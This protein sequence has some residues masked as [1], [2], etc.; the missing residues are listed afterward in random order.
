MIL[1]GVQPD[2]PGNAG[3]ELLTGDAASAD[4]ETASRG[5]RVRVVNSPDA[6]TDRFEIGWQSGTPTTRVGTPMAVQVPPGQSRVVSLPRPSTTGADRIVLTGDAAPFDNT[7]FVTARPT[8]AVVLRYVGP[9]TDRS[10]RAPLYFLERALP[11][12]GTPPVTWMQQAAAAPALGGFQTFWKL[13]VVAAAPSPAVTDSIRSQAEEGA[14]ALVLVNTPEAVERLGALLGIADL[15][16]TPENPPGGALLVDIDFRHPLFAPFADPRFSDFSRMRIW[17]PMRLDPTRIPGAKVLARLDSGGPALMEVPMGRGRIV[18]V[19]WGWS[20]ADSQW[21][22]STKFV[23]FL[24]ALVDHSG[25]LPA[26]QTATVAVGDPLPLSASAGG[27]AWTLELP[28]GDRVPI[29]DS[30][31]PPTA[32]TTPGIH[33]LVGDGPVREWAVNLAPAESRTA[34]TV[35]G[36]LDA[37]GVPLRDRSRAEVPAT[38][39]PEIQAAAAAEGRQKLWRWFLAS[40]LL[41]L[42]IETLAAGW[43]SRRSPRLPEGQTA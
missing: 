22:L 27:P 10:T 28:S 25:A 26:E 30:G 41:I 3:I 32:T 2:R 14:T 19:P 36:V 29:P 21:V 39:T 24:M 23:P 5:V 1:D 11:E 17:R 16:G 40:T 20:P 6:T 8:N 12:R 37:L 31:T 35:S 15:T 13:T 18:I 38:T 34:P 9:G 7:V 42:A 43:A 33:R 4:A